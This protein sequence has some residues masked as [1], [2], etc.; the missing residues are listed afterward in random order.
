MLQ[1]CVGQL[2]LGATFSRF[3]VLS[4]LLLLTLVSML[5]TF[6]RHDVDTLTLEVMSRMELFG[7]HVLPRR[8]DVYSAESR[9]S[10]ALQ[11]REQ[12][13]R[14]HTFVEMATFRE[15]RLV[16]PE[17]GP[18]LPLCIGPRSVCNRCRPHSRK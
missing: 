15:K 5:F 2:S 10:A 6:A 1:R 4:T 11:R 3:D 18:L 17:D 14:C 7:T 12:V 9:R 16:I 8:R 13:C